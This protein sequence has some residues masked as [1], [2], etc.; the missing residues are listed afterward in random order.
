MYT[1]VLKD[2]I[3]AGC[4][5]AAR[6][7]AAQRGFASLAVSGRSA[8]SSASLVHDGKQAP[9][10][11]TCI[12]VQPSV[13]S[14]RLLHSTAPAQSNVLIGG[15]SLA[16][17]A[18]AGSYAIRAFQAANAGGDAAAAPT[19]AG[20][21]D[22]KGAEAPKSGESAKAGPEGAQQA[23]T[24]KGFG[25]EFFAKRFY[26]GPFEDKMTKREASLILGVRESASPERI[27]DRYK[28]MLMLNHPDMGGSTFIA[29]KINE[30]KDVLLGK[31]R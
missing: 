16:A 13:G 30:A 1:S 11:S 29:G 28:K 19:E 10:G 3:R 26:R 20:A 27:R 7:A 22:V 2:S 24:H 6:T 4:S 18:M 9:N 23:A 8:I 15:L 17:A 5:S 31:Q 25:A 14:L 12:L 21:P